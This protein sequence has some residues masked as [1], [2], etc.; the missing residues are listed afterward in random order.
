MSLNIQA[1][2]QAVNTLEELD[3]FLTGL[4]VK[5]GIFCGRTC[6]KPGVQGEVSLNDITRRFREITKPEPEHGEVGLLDI[7]F[8]TQQLKSKITITIVKLGAEPAP[9]NRWFARVRQSVS[10]FFYNRWKILAEI[11]SEGNRSMA[12]AIRLAQ[13]Y[14]SSFLDPTVG[15]IV[16]SVSQTLQSTDR[17]DGFEKA[18]KVISDFMR[19][20][21]PGIGKGS[22]PPVN[23][24]RERAVLKMARALYDTHQPK[25]QNLAQAVIGQMVV[26]TQPQ[27]EGEASTQAV[28]RRYRRI[29]GEQLL[30]A[31]SS[32]VNEGQ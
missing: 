7:S 11:N 18:K 29:L 21:E 20:Q 17:A 32:K 8:A 13:P 25:L 28:P 31:A 27:K 1:S 26:S 5:H 9:V 23:S 3:T 4:T 14:L 2:L 22:V 10:T 19:P 16:E 6:T 12:Q 24:A 30:R 15:E